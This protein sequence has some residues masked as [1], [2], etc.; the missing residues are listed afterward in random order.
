MPFGRGRAD[1]EALEAAAQGRLLSASTMRCRWLPCTLNPRCAGRSGRRDAPK[2]P[3][4]ARETSGGPAEVPTPRSPERD[5]RGLGSSNRG[6]ALCDTRRAGLL[7]AP[8]ALPAAAQW[9]DRAVRSHLCLGYI[10][11]TA[12]CPS[13]KARA[14]CKLAT[15]LKGARALVTGCGGARGRAIA[16]ELAREA[17]MWRCTP[18]VAAGRRADGGRGSRAGGGRGWCRGTRRWSRLGSSTRR[19]KGWAGWSWWS[20]APRFREDAGGAPHPPAVRGDARHQPH[21]AV[22]AHAGGAAVAAARRAEH[23]QPARPLRYSAG[24]ERLCA[25]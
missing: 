9:A 6:R 17:R 18:L 22:S 15:M 20:A 24:L 16:L 23:R 7:L 11:S 12:P 21:R 13:R 2:Q 19:P 25:L 14:G 8:C 4:Q 5:V 10:V 1:A 3:A